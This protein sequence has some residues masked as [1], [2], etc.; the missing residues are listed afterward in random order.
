[1]C[2]SPSSIQKYT[3]ICAIETSSNSKYGTVHHA[4]K[5][6]IS[7]T[8][9]FLT[10]F[11]VGLSFSTFL[12]PPPPPPTQ[13]LLRFP[14]GLT[15]HL[16]WEKMATQAEYYGKKVPRKIV[17][18]TIVAAPECPICGEP[19][20]SGLK[21]VCIQVGGRGGPHIP[22]SQR[23]QARLVLTF[24]LFPFF[25]FLNKKGLRA[26]C[27][28]SCH[29]II[30][31]WYRSPAIHS[32]VL[33]SHL[34]PRTITWCGHNGHSPPTTTTLSA[35]LSSA[36]ESARRS[37]VHK[38]GLQAHCVHRLLSWLDRSANQLRQYNDLV[39][40]AR[41]VTPMTRH[42]VFVYSK[43]LMGALTP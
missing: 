42:F 21:R 19:S 36:G 25:F 37:A 33:A 4:T 6:H 39:P 11:L 30:A 40:N 9:V 12:T 41:P 1:M 32:T 17:G 26:L 20:A 2:I 43:T 24:S 31:G 18:G 22:L 23:V 13:T 28:T 34:L 16:F 15:R 10:C 35:L 8:I 5:T 29:L 27:T 3:R 7:Y 38:D 14:A